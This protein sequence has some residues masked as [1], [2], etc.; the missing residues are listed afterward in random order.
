MTDQV[1]V[2]GIGYYPPKLD[3]GACSLGP[4]NGGILANTDFLANKS[5]ARNFMKA[6]VA[7]IREMQDGASFR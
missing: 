3:I 4:A 5:L 1:V 7:S 6:Y 2:E